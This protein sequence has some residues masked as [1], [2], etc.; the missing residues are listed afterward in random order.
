MVDLFSCWSNLSEPAESHQWTASKVS[1][2]A[3]IARTIDGGAAL[4]FWIGEEIAPSL[5]RLRT[6]HIEYTR[7]RE[8]SIR[9]DGVTEFGHYAVL[10][11]SGLDAELV[12]H[13]LRVAATLP[14]EGTPADLEEAI[15]QLFELFRSLGH[16]ATH[17]V[18]GIWAETFVA[19]F[20]TDPALLVA[21]WHSDP[22]DLHDF[23]GTGYQLEV[24]SSARNL[25]EHEFSLEQLERSP[26]TTIVVS[27]LLDV[28]EI[29]PNVFDLLEVLTSRLP[30]GLA[31]RAE[32]IVSKALGDAWR[33]ADEVRYSVA[34]AL[35][36]LQIFAAEGI[37]RPP[38]PMPET[39]SNLKFRSDLSG[40]APDVTLSGQLV[41]ALPKPGKAATAK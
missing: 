35:S 25:R 33:E 30:A 40:L 22:E 23:V 6:S 1:R 39:V 9:T 21:A 34:T 16:R 27:I 10:Q 28:D 4:L 29:G 19:A 36:K 14:D 7:C 13:F 11:C 18:Q 12:R 3:R 20:A 2:R 31:R 26:Q 32:V 17:T 41:T 24:K 8:L 15:L 38:G 5:H 37:P